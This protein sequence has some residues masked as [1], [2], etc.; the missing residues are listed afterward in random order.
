MTELRDSTWNIEQKIRRNGTYW[1]Q[2]WL[3]ATDGASY[4]PLSKIPRLYHP[5]T[6]CWSG[7]V[8]GLNGAPPVPDL[9]WWIL[10]VLLGKDISTRPPNKNRPVLGRS[11]EQLSCFPSMTHYIPE[12]K[13]GST[14]ALKCRRKERPS[15]VGTGWAFLENS[16]RV[17]HMSSYRRASSKILWHWSISRSPLVVIISQVIWRRWIHSTMSFMYQI[18][19]HV[20]R[21]CKTSG[22]MTACS[23]H[24]FAQTSRCKTQ[25]SLW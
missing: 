9:R 23:K 20:W 1:I 3:A 17:F 14:K 24:Q 21:T 25:L 7:L 18:M 4:C 6:D 13:E 2:T 15:R 12:S 5:N 8:L 22:F 16:R 19:N 10:G 11:D